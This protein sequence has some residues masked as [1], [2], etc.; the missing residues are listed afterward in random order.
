MKNVN[1][2]PKAGTEEYEQF[3]TLVRT[4][5][6]GFFQRIYKNLDLTIPIRLWLTGTEEYPRSEQ[7]QA[8][9]RTLF[10]QW[11]KRLREDT[12]PLYIALSFPPADQW[13]RERVRWAARVKRD[14][15]R[16]WKVL[17]DLVTWLGARD[18]K[19]VET[20]HQVEN[21]EFE[22]LQVQL[23]AF[24]DT[25]YDQTCLE[26]LK[27]AL[28]VY[29]QRATALCPALL[30][31]ALPIQYRFDCE[32]GKGG[33]YETNHIILC[34][35]KEPSTLV[36][37]LA[38]EMGHHVYR[39]ILA[40]DAKKYWE[41]AVHQD[42][43]ELDL[44]HLLSLWPAGDVDI[45]D[46]ERILR[47]TDPLLSLQVAGILYGWSQH[48]SRPEWT[49]KGQLEQWLKDG[50]EAS[51]VVPTHPVSGY[52][53]K[54]AE[55]A[56]CEVMGLLIGYGPR[57][58]DSLVRSW[59][60]T[61]T[62]QLVRSAATKLAAVEE[63]AEELGVKLDLHRNRHYW[64]L[65]RI[66]VP[67]EARGTG[68]GTQIMRA[69]TDEA[70][71]AGATIAL[72]PSKDFGASSVS[73]LTK[74]YKQF[75]FVEN[76]GRKR[77]LTIS[78]TMFRL[79]KTAA[80]KS[81]ETLK[82]LKARGP[83]VYDVD[84]SAGPF[85]ATVEVQIPD[86]HTWDKREIVTLAMVVDSDYLQMDSF[87]DYEDDLLRAAG[88]ELGVTLRWTEGAWGRDT[89]GV[90]TR[91]MHVVSKSR[92]ADTEKEAAE[93]T[94]GLWD[95]MVTKVREFSR[96][97]ANVEP[98]DDYEA[99]LSLADIKMLTGIAEREKE[100][101]PLGSPEWGAWYW[102]AFAGKLPEGVVLEAA[103]VEDPRN[104][105]PSYEAEEVLDGRQPFKF[106]AHAL[107]KHLKNLAG[108][109]GS[110]APTVFEYQGLKIRNPDRLSEELARRTLD[111]IDYVVALF[112]KR[113]MLPLLHKGVRFVELRTSFPSTDNL[114][115]L[116]YYYA[117][118]KSIRLS[119]AAVVEKSPRLL[120]EWTHE[121]FLHEFG[122][123]IHLD[124]LSPDAKAA[125][126][127][128]WSK[129]Q[130]KKDEKQQLFDR[131]G[132]ISFEERS[133]FW[134][135]MLYNGWDPARA[136]KK[137]QG[138]DKIKFGAWLRTPGVGDPLITPKQL[139]LTE[140]G[141]YMQLFFTDTESFMKK[142]YDLTP[143]DARYK[144]TQERRLRRFMDKMGL[145]HERAEPIPREI[146]EEL[147]KDPALDTA[148]QQ[149]IEDLDIVTDYGR[150]NEKEDFAETFV[151]FMDA[152]Q[153]LTPMARQRMQ[154]CL[155]LSGL[156]GKPVTRLSA[157]NVEK[158]EGDFIIY[159]APQINQEVVDD[160]VTRVHTAIDQYRS[161]G[162]PLND[163]LRI[164]LKRVGGGSITLADYSPGSNPPT[165]GI[166][167]KAYKR[168]D[169]VSVIIHEL[170]H[171][172]HDKVVP[173]GKKN[174]EIQS[175][176]SWALGE[177][178][179]APP[180]KGE[181]FEFQYRGGWLDYSHSNKAYPMTG[182]I[183]GKGRG[184]NV[185]VMILKYPSEILD[186][187][188]LGLSFREHDGKPKTRPVIE[189]DLDK[190]LYKGKQVEKSDRSYEGHQHD[191]VP[192]SYSKSNSNEW[193]AELVATFVL[194]HLLEAPASWL[195]SVIKTGEATKAQKTS[196]AGD[197][198]LVRAV[199]GALDDS[200]R[201]PP[202]KGSENPMT[203]H[204]YVASEALYHL[205][206]GR[207]AG[208]TPMF[209]AHEGSP[210]WF[211][212][213][214]DGRIL[215]ATASQFKTPVPYDNARGKGFLTNQPSKRAQIVMDRVRKK[216]AAASSAADFFDGFRQRHPQ[217]PCGPLTA[218]DANDTVEARQT[219][220]TVRLSP[221]FWQLPAAMQDFVFAHEVGHYW[222]SAFGL[223]RA[224]E[225]LEEHDTS[226][227]DNLP[228]AQFNVEEALADAFA[229]HFL[230]PAE[231]DDLP[232][233]S[234]VVD[235][236]L[237]SN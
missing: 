98:S 104:T 94:S 106:F 163:K 15:R 196:T 50:H 13:E 182:E 221:K 202:Y 211:L 25:D 108:I 69:I 188:K 236:L 220:E 2:L 83:G 208:W 86:P 162:L 160:I 57:A 143:T 232:G 192:T 65:S 190:L 154:R 174:E 223:Q 41:T 148:I 119:A 80:T 42:L 157:A 52:G 158:D 32:V 39:T 20:V 203:G 200:L 150:T 103:G 112:K 144:E 177:V 134:D 227:W 145:L 102:Q 47:N 93:G 198:A 81:A 59:F 209:I 226:P 228:F 31:R 58:V 99:D 136:G 114:I 235:A 205:L 14:A 75:G 126:D 23:Y 28:K 234:A 36:R 109:L 210:H 125:W 231:L 180:R 161:S 116:G 8:R 71:A 194:G 45:Y 38:H 191:W 139:R 56:F 127:A 67:A 213:N 153:K 78:E 51:W 128:G 4:W 195:V 176:Y 3:R 122:H 90:S 173:G 84:V 10:E 40:D 123:Y 77:D 216:T 27:H 92:K 137:L 97:V 172:V 170:G 146:A 19:A 204:C 187:P 115:P 168:K 218:V 167:S 1:V 5:R 165:I 193:F 130:E 111:G 73:R 141:K 140:S 225:L 54:N 169:L 46:F 206:G 33:R 60:D 229:N 29:R 79:P 74:F 171:Y 100:Y 152:P 207:K 35:N 44:R 105:Y 107:D 159:H 201:R 96:L 70:D 101:N 9:E 138:I 66:V 129:V 124:Y 18:V 175:R 95:A 21:H 156:Y 118:E 214:S 183:I 11:Q 68:V 217:I 62:N 164:E 63:L 6:E 237:A 117:G 133:R 222:V 34:A 24:E 64:T 215:D 55:E 85:A 179:A 181:A 184:K 49:T 82:E 233:W 155:A 26:A 113:D 61:V 230:D 76:R 131:M 135:L 151:A 17:N 48:Q 132:K 197:A 199:Q 110:T 142:E 219:G 147:T 120:H 30:K 16:A 178:Q 121:I 43:G 89:N 87:E 12:W 37:Y 22:G 224:I 72:S 212:K 53:H 185:R 149:A 186:D 91:F 166:T 88:D 189:L 7:L